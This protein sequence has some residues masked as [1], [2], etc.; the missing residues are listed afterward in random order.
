MKKILLLE[1]DAS[2]IDELKYSLS[3]NGFFLLILLVLL[4]KLR[5]F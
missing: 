1:D 2:L 4:R 5:Y 3:K